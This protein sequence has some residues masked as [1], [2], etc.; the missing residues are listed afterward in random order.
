MAGEPEGR[1]RSESAW[2]EAMD[3]VRFVAEAA[4]LSSGIVLLAW[5]LT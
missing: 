1:M 2:R 5:F 3:L 4:A